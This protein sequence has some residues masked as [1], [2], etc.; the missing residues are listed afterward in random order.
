MKNTA[1]VD[2]ASLNDIW[3]TDHTMKALLDT[4]LFVDRSAI[5]QYWGM[6]FKPETNVTNAY[7]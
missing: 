7:A 4:N 6:I 3:H 1:I 2:T 5:Y